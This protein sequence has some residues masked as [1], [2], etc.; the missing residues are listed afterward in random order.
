MRFKK[1]FLILF[2]SFSILTINKAFAQQGYQ[3][4]PLVPDAPYVNPTTHTVDI[5]NFI[6]T[7][8][9]TMIAVAGALTVIF[10]MIGGIK[11]MTTDSFGGKSDAKATIQ[12]AIFGFVLAIGSYVILYTIN[13]S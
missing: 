5:T 4:T 6:S 9:K 13:P 2:I 8:I 1:I 3:Y 11:Y 10:I 12:N 7:A